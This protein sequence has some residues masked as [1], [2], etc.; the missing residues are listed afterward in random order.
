MG[1]YIYYLQGGYGTGSYCSCRRCGRP[2]SRYSYQ[3]SGYDL[4]STCAMDREMQLR[5]RE[6]QQ[7]EQVKAAEAKDKQFK[8]ELEKKSQEK[9]LL[10]L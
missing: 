3:S 5:E 2:I 4:C 1:D 9:L 6:R 8:L 7:L 10:L